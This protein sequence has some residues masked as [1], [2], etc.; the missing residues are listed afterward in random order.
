MVM[1]PCAAVLC[2]T[3]LRCDSE[4]HRNRNDMSLGTES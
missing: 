3:P 4:G 2:C 1:D